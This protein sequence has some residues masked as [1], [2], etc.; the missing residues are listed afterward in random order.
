M[1]TR[2][3][4]LE[5]AVP[6]KTI[7]ES[8]ACLR[9]LNNR[10]FELIAFA[11]CVGTP[12]KEAKE[13]SLRKSAYRLCKHHNKR[14]AEVDFQERPKFDVAIITR[15]VSMIILLLSAKLGLLPQ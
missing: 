4:P 8:R 15:P 10:N 13:K 5:L 1:R 6:S 12:K 7:W 14:P 9:S 2:S 3:T 11:T